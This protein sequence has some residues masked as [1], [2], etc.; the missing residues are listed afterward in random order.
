MKPEAT[1]DV[2][3]RAGG[4]SIWREFTQDRPGER[5]LRL[6]QRRQAARTGC[7]PGEKCVNLLGGSALAVLGV[8]LIPA[9]GPGLLLFAAGMAL[10]GTEFEGIARAMDG[11]EEQFLSE[12][13]A[14]WT[15]ARR[16]WGSR[17][18]EAAASGRTG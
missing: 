11:A 9:P 5:F 8:L 14:C 10:L 17:G 3:M 16:R 2:Q 13:R 18:A 12:A 15:A 6:R 7:C 1:S 4:R